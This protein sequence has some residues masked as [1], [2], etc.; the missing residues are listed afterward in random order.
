MNPASEQR[1]ACRS[2]PSH[3]SFVGLTD[4]Q[5]AI[6]GASDR[7]RTCLSRTG[8]RTSEAA[9]QSMRSPLLVAYRGADRGFF[10]DD[11]HTVMLDG[12]IDNLRALAISTGG[13]DN[14]ETAHDAELIAGLFARNGD[15]IFAGFTGSFS[16]AIVT[17][18]TGEVVLVRDRFGDR[19][20]FYG[21]TPGGW[22][23]ASEIKSLCPL[24]DSVE[25]DSE[26]LR[27][28]IHYRYVLG[29]TLIGGVSQVMPACFVRLAAGRSPV[30]T[31][32]WKLEFRPSKA[33]SSLEAWADLVD[34]GLDACFA[35]LR[36]Q[37]RDIAILLSGG[38]DSSLLAAKA[39]RSG[40]RT[41]VAL[42]ARWPGENPELDAARDVARHI[43]IEHRIIDID[44]S[45]LEKSFPWIVW[46]LE[47]P[48]R[49]YNSFVLAKLFGAA[50]GQF[51]TL[52]SGHAA[53][54]L[55]GPPGIIEL[56]KFQRR[57]SQLE[58]IPRRLQEYLA[59]LLGD[60][61]SGHFANLKKCLETGEDEFTQSYFRIQYRDQGNI[62]RR[63]QLD[64]SLPS[65]RSIER[66]YDPLESAT[67]RFQRFDLYTFNQSHTQVFDRLG[68]PHGINVTSP[69]LAPEIVD[70]AER[71]PSRLK[72]DGHI[73]KPVLK[74]LAARFFPKEWIY[75]EHQGF[76]TRHHV[77]SKARSVTGDVRCLTS[78]W[79]PAA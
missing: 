8:S 7:W 73:A 55:F 50:S 69:F 14:L 47:E 63:H 1:V 48:P 25:L 15:A 38:V 64:P 53:D 30:E 59:T 29:D 67:E 79:H 36:D 10:E 68:V 37:Y 6:V 76:P 54:V 26:G 62:L 42:T 70:I 74:T 65:R 21:M 12:L 34:A 27:Q 28:A 4:P 19:P 43:G 41:C 78:E 45:Y 24:L 31:L 77:G 71:L 60:S 17:R 35:R 39:A 11:R 46:R 23:W 56:G 9:R 52:L 72:A 22:A 33:I 66:F 3:A 44:E 51:D 13:F 61:E 49:H 2:A 5:C 58:I 40:F 75:R 32:Y 57:L 16:L 18:E 20:L